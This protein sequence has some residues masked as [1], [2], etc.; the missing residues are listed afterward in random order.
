M[1]Y[2]HSKYEVQMVPQTPGV[3]TGV[4]TNMT[5]TFN[6][7]GTFFSSTGAVGEWG[8]G[9]VPHLIKGVAVIRETG[10]VDD[11]VWN[12]RFQHIKGPTNTATNIANIVMP[13]TVTSPGQAVYYVPTNEVEIKPGEYVRAVVTATPTY[14]TAGKIMLYVEPRWEIPGNVTT[15]ILTTGKPS[16]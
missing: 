12:V 13:T 3:S 7:L 2:T 1:A 10:T 14:R 4:A 11:A 15:M 8:P 9:M 5:A 16:D 6:R